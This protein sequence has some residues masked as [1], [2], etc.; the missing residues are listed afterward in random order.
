MVF[1]F[2]KH[3]ARMKMKLR[4]IKKSVVFL[5]TLAVVLTMVACNYT[6]ENAQSEDIEY[7]DEFDGESFDEDTE[8]GSESSEEMDDDIWDDLLH[9]YDNEQIY[10]EDVPISHSS[11]GDFEYD[12]Y[13]SGICIVK[14]L[15]NDTKVII[16]DKINNKP[17]LQLGSGEAILPENMYPKM[18]ELEIPSSV[19][20]I[21]DSALANSYSLKVK[22]L[23]NNI[24][25][26]GR[27]ALRG[28]T[29]P[30]FVWP[31]GVPVMNKGV[32]EYARIGNFEIPDTLRQLGEDG[33]HG[34]DIK[35][36][37]IPRWIKEIPTGCIRACDNL[38]EVKIDEGV[39][40]IGCYAFGNNDSLKQMTLPESV[41]TLWSN[42]FTDTALTE[43][44][45]P[46][47]ITETRDPMLGSAP[48]IFEE[49]T[50]LKV[51]RD[52]YMQEYASE[53]GF[54]FEIY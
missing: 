6:S 15:G 54:D 17:I 30:N 44:Y 20:S 36:I 24:T 35:S 48:S 51:K 13:D 38:T 53:T 10:A 42:A 45:L 9:E 11:S 14:Y 18:K 33:L 26:L 28:C 27:Y 49:G 16:P 34:T 29:L 37:H 8:D 12:E 3:H 47:S 19:I 43:I 5:F 32:L 23:T 31:R 41:K 46:A 4:I 22:G 21:N 52:S 25:Y 1:Y 39:E 7:G 40:S 50:L 2:Y